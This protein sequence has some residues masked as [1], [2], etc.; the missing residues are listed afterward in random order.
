VVLA[1]RRASRLEQVAGECRQRGG[2]AL[3]VPTDV[4]VEPACRA[5]VESTIQAFGRLDLLV[6]NAGLAASARPEDFPN[7]CLFQQV[8]AVN[9]YGAVYTTYHALPHLQRSRGRIVVISS[10]AGKAA[11]PYT[12]PYVASKHALHGFCDTLRMEVAPRGV[13]VT[14]VC[15]SWVVTEFHEAQLDKD[16]VPR[17]ARGRSLYTRR[18][19]SAERCAQIVLAAAH[20]RRREVLMWPGSL[21]VWLKMLAPGA[22]D[23]LA[24]KLFL[25]PAIRRARGGQLPPG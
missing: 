2:Q 16:G 10:L 3:A 18:T 9:F 20:R 6:K 5:L 4:S 24:V 13:S 25:E 14:V 15:P 17:G 22:V 12:S 7:L 11:L 19:M 21:A 1:A 23:W 8:M